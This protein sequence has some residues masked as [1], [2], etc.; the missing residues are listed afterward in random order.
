MTVSSLI[1]QIMNH[2]S[3]QQQIQELKVEVE[4]M[5]AAA[6]GEPLEKLRLIEQIQRLGIAYRFKREIDE[7]LEQIYKLYFESDASGYHGDH[8]LHN[9]ALLFRILR[10]QGYR[11]SS[12]I[13]VYTS[14]RL[15]VFFLL[16]Y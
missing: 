3:A 13:C 8:D 7:S 2:D 12:G 1:T 15:L 10:E 5:L 9:T 16:I 4:R 14:V 6:D 11:I